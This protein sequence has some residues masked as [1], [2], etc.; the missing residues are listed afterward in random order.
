MK[1]CRSRDITYPT[2]SDDGQGVAKRRRVDDVPTVLLS[3][4]F[5]KAGG[6]QP[7]ARCVAWA[8]EHLVQ[9]DTKLTPMVV[10]SEEVK[11]GGRRYFAL[12]RQALHHYHSSFASNAQR[13]LH[14]VVPKN[15]PC[16][17]YCDF[18]YKMDGEVSVEELERDSKKL[19]SLMRASAR[20]Q[21]GA[22]LVPFVTQ[23]H[24]TSKWSKH[25]V[26][27]GAIWRSSA[28]CA[29]FVRALVDEKKRFSRFVDVGVYGGNHCMRMLHSSKL[30]EPNRSLKVCER[31]HPGLVLDAEQLLERSLISGFDL[32]S[33]TMRRRALDLADDEW[34]SSIFISHF[35]D[36]MHTESDE[37]LR[38]IEHPEARRSTSASSDESV[39]MSDSTNSLMK[40]SAGGASFIDHLSHEKCGE[41]SRPQVIADAATLFGTETFAHLKPQK[42]HAVPDTTL[43]VLSCESHDCTIAQRRHKKNHIF[44]LIDATRQRWRQ[45]CHNEQCRRQLSIS[46]E[47]RWNYFEQNSVEANAC[48]ALFG[49]TALMQPA[50]PGL[51]D[52]LPTV[53]VL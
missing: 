31:S 32:D 53:L 49:T 3:A 50:A 35:F 47:S 6:E 41:L 5:D 34:A 52:C 8:F 27:S 28:D 10:V 25:V 37:P 2:M 33:Y 7:L 17:L 29:A 30:D 15:S 24:K 19:I 39:S 20:E 13:H 38:L 18:E 46:P 23:S 44:I 21:F 1:W 11:R 36:Q 9:G 14:E 43:F 26:F 48:N 40:S 4:T 45:Q 51:S 12:S 42:F 16:R 22:K